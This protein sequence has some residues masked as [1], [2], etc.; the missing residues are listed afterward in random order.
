MVKRHLDLLYI[1]MSSCQNRTTTTDASTQTVIKVFPHI[2]APFQMAKASSDKKMQTEIS[3]KPDD[4]IE[5]FYSLLR[6]TP[7]QDI[8]ENCLRII[9]LPRLVQLQFN[10]KVAFDK[11][12][13]M[14]RQFS[15]ADDDGVGY[16]CC[17]LIHRLDRMQRRSLTDTG[18]QTD[19]KV[20]PH[21]LK[22]QEVAIVTTSTT[23]QTDHE[24]SAVKKEN[25]P[26]TSK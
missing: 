25:Q 22:E 16:I 17:E 19:M 9:D 13:Q 14:A 24:V 4:R 10:P 11:M 7:Y 8:Q 20:A 15:L 2:L 21:L 26:T 3:I 1:S 5:Q 23:L 18:M 12:S 6:F